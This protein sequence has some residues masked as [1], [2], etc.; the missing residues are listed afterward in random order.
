MYC[1]NCGERNS[2]ES[3]YCASCGAKLTETE[4]DAAVA[5]PVPEK[6]KTSGMAVAALV[7]GIVG[8]FFNILGVLAII[9][10]AIGMSQTGRDKNL[11]GRGM[12]I[13]GLVLGIIDILFWVIV[14][15]LI[16]SF[17][18]FYA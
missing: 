4:S 15:A 11:G 16:G 8:F 3:K 12:A 18:A 7:L 6:K 14:I 9:F 13:A 1:P 5:V 17:W 2:P 10:G